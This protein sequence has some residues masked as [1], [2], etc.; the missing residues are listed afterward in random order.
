MQLKRQTPRQSERDRPEGRLAGRFWKV[1]LVLLLFLTCVGFYLKSVNASRNHPVALYDEVAVLDLAR[2]FKDRGSLIQVVEDYLCG[3]VTEDNRHPLYP[4][5]L[6]GFMKQVPGDFAEAKVL[7]LTVGLTL[8]LGVFLLSNLLWGVEVGCLSALF[9]GVSPVM[10]Y[11]SS[12]AT[13]DLLFACLYFVSLAVL[14]RF[15]GRCLAWLAYGVM[16]GLAY[17]TKGNGHLL[18]LPALVLGLW[19]HKQA[20]LKKPH[21]YLA[22]FGFACT[23]FF[24]IYRNLLVFHDPFHNVNSK[25]FWLDSWPDYYLLSSGPEWGRVGFSW[26]LSHHSFAQILLRLFHGIQ[27]TGVMLLLSMG[28]GPRSC[29]F[30]SGV[31]MLGLA[32]CG[33][34]LQ[35]RDGHRQQVVVVA[36]MGCLFFLLFSWYG[37][38]AGGD[39]RFIF[40]V[41]VSLIP[42]SSVGVI[43]LYGFIRKKFAK[44]PRPRVLIV[45]LVSLIGLLNIALERNAFVIAPLQLSCFPAEWQE[46]SRWIRDHIKD[47]E[48]LLN[49]R[50]CFSQWDCCR[51]RR[52]NYPF[53][54]PGEFLKNYALKSGIKYILVDQSLVGSDPFKEKYGMPDEYGPTTFLGLPRCYHDNQKP[55]LFLIYSQECR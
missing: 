19:N 47:E 40:P 36:G 29:L 21:F 3:H 41:A 28:P 13:P 5:V 18:L 2:D 7:N 23:A 34:V 26:Y 32:L 22:L 31:I 9:L 35:W 8:I 11:L 38:A 30:A 4:M 20:F 46:T 15:S 48:F 24:L 25:V 49:N 14:M 33:L 55:S 17:L 53:E 37:Q 44:A 1:A 6:S 45:A 42:F 52:K 16:C 12:Q 10:V 54:I 50:S 43:S 51:D 27:S 39:V